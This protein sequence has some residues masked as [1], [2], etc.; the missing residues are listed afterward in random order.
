[1]RGETSIQDINIPGSRTDEDKFKF[2]MTSAAAC[3]MKWTGLN[4]LSREVLFIRSVDISLI[5]LMY[6]KS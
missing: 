2:V 4:L 5:C 1:M 3:S 6:L